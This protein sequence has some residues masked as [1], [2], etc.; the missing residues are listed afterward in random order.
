MLGFRKHFATMRDQRRSRRAIARPSPG[1]GDRV[2]QGAPLIR[3]AGLQDKTR[4]SDVG[5]PPHGLAMARLVPWIDTRPFEDDAAQNPARCRLTLTR[6]GPSEQPVVSV[7]LHHLIGDD[8]GRAPHDHGRAGAER[9]AGDQGEGQKS[10]HCSGLRVAFPA[11]WGGTRA[12]ARSRRFAAA[13]VGPR[14]PGQRPFPR[15]LP[16]GIRAA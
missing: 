11:R 3:R 13:R 1:A 6:L 9:Q 12:V 15:T 8:I 7:L 14:V 2:T 5:S 4:R 16:T 10:G